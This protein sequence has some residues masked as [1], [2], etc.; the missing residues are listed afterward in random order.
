MVD[1]KK[2]KIPVGKVGESMWFYACQYCIAH[3]FIKSELNVHEK[4]CNL[5]NKN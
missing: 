1:N 3:F 2:M 5:K 4:T